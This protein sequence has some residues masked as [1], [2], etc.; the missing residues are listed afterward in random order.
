[1]R[2]LQGQLGKVWEGQEQQAEL[3]EKTWRTQTEHARSI[4][5]LWARLETIR[6]E[7]MVEIR[8]GARSGEGSSAIETRILDEAKVDAG[9][10]GGLRINVGCGHLPLDGYVNVDLRE[11]PGVDVVATVSDMPFEPGELAELFSAHLVEH[12]PQEQLERELLPYWRSLIR[13]GGVLRMVVPDGGAMLEGFASGDINWGDLREVLYGGQE[14]E[15]DF[16]FNMY[17][18][19]TLPKLLE[20]AGFESVSVEAAGRRNGIALEMQ[21]VAHVPQ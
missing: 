20:N 14:Y 3:L 18:T 19:E 12:F 4:N 15:G 8:Y 10:R 9:R 7:L 21:L 17:T 6:R 1:M 2:E 5:D 13:P 16:H 11:L